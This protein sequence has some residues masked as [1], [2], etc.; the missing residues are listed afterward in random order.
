VSDRD[1]L[2]VRF[3]P[4]ANPVVVSAKDYGAATPVRRDADPDMARHREAVRQTRL[5]AAAFTTAHYLWWGFAFPVYA[6]VNDRSL[7]WAGLAVAAGL[8]VAIAGLYTVAGRARHDIRDVDEEIGVPL[9]T[10]LV[11]EVAS[12]GMAMHMLGALADGAPEITARLR[13]Y[14][15]RFAAMDRTYVRQLHRARQAWVNGD[16]KRWRAAAQKAID[17]S[18]RT[19]ELLGTAGVLP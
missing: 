1:W 9:P 10:D 14:R 12:S 19:R 6:L 5:H 18:D 4:F 8:G 15:R 7:L 17:I 13:P 11:V 3:L 16:R 2:A